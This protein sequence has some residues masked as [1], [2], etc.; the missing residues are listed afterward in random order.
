MV[1]KGRGLP[2]NS[3]PPIKD[4]KMA[5]KD[6][7]LIVDTETSQDSMVADFGAIIVDRKGN[8]YS[9]CAVLVA[10]IY[11]DMEN[12]PLFFTSD[13]TGIW[14]KRGQDKRYGMYSN[15]LHSGTRMLASV[16]AINIWL[17]KAKEKYNP[18]LTAYNL[19]FDDGKC[20]NTGIDLLQFDKR[21][22]L[23]HAAYTRWAHT[24]EYRNMCLA[25]HAFNAPTELGNMS[26]K[27]NAET[28]ARFVTGNAKMEAEPHSALEDAQLYEL[29]I[30][31]KLV[32]ST[33]K[34]KWL[35]PESFNWRNVQ[36]N[37]WFKPS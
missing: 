34:E 26:F 11:N 17:A 20:S 32:N 10:G 5:K 27:T 19:P 36:V 21:F 23:W 28:M 12:H 35:N 30:L 6:Y 13:K 15:M 37:K 4:L 2:S 14:S 24:K 18:Y 1:F 8:I 25:T 29:P 3:S 16:A 31:L 33:K 9:T 7:F 22:C